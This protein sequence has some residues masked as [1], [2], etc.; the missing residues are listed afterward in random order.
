MEED[1]GRRCLQLLCIVH[2][3]GDGG[4][5]GCLRQEST[6]YWGLRGRLP[7]YGLQ[8]LS[9]QVK[10]ILNDNSYLHF[11]AVIMFLE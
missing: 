10:T 7:C 11:P 9:R 1:L 2:G 6:L 3:A 4:I 8:E 5:P